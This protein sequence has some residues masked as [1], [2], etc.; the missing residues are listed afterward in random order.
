MFS[1]IIQIIVIS[2]IFIMIVDNIYQFLKDSLTI[3]KKHDLIYAPNE[4]Y[5][6]MLDILKM[7]G[8]S[9]QNSSSTNNKTDTMQSTS[10][11]QG[12]TSINDIPMVPDSLDH[13]SS[14]GNSILSSSKLAPENAESMKTELKNFMKQQLSS[15]NKSSGSSRQGVEFS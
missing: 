3:P 15:V 9:F 14:Q 13:V 8:T 10:S 5:K 2:I 11:M 7:S 4:K 1:K 6:Q 12:A